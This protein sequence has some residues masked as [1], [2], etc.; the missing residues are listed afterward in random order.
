MNQTIQLVGYLHFWKPPYHQ[1]K[2]HQWMMTGVSA[3]V[4]YFRK[5]PHLFQ[6]HLAPPSADPPG[7]S[8]S[9]GSV[10]SKRGKEGTRRQAAGD[11]ALQALF[12]CATVPEKS[13]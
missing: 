13:L 4:S 5:P 3:A 7:A 1:W 10:P 8:S 6:R 12:H 2:N 11:G 9:K